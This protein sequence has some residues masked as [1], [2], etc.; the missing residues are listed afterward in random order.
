MGLNTVTASSADGEGDE[1]PGPQELPHRHA[2]GAHHGELA[3]AAQ[4]QQAP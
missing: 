1:Q 4:L 3:L 2:A